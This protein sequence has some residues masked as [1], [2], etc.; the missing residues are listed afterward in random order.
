MF[1]MVGHPDIIQ[2]AF[3]QFIQ[4]SG[5]LC[6]LISSGEPTVQSHIALMAPLF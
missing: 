5:F 3:D 2:P 6:R 4:I 1:L